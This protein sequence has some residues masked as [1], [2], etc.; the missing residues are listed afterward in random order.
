MVQAPETRRP[1]RGRGSRS[2]RKKTGEYLRN[3]YQAPKGLRRKQKI[4]FAG[5]G[6]FILLLVADALY[7]GAGLNKHMRLAADEL[8][9]GYAA[10]GSGN[11]AE[12][13]VHFDRAAE[14]A[15]TANGLSAHPTVYMASVLPVLEDDVSVVRSLPPAATLAAQAGQRSVEAARSL[16]GTD[17][18]SLARA[19][20]RDGQIQL[21]TVVQTD[22]YLGEIEG[23]LTEAEEELQDASPPHLG[24]VKEAL[25]RSLE[26]ISTARRT[27]TRSHVLLEMLPSFFGAEEPREYLLALQN[28]SEAR[29]TGGVI[30]IYGVLEADDG[31]LKLTHAGPIS[32]LTGKVTPKAFEKVFA[33]APSL[34]AYSAEVRKTYEV[35]YT[36][37]FDQ[38]ARAF[39]DLYRNATGRSLD[40]VIMTDPVALAE[41]TKATGPIQGTG[42]D[43]PVGPDNAVQLMLHDAYE[44]FRTDTQARNAF[45]VSLIKNFYKALSDPLDAPVFV[46]SFGAASDSRHVRILSVDPADQ[47][48]LEE[49]GVTGGLPEDGN[50]QLIYHNN[51]G[52][53]GTDFFLER[54][55]E[56]KVAI[57]RDGNLEVSGELTLT[58]G[59]SG[60]LTPVEYSY[61]RLVD[62]GVNWMELNLLMPSGSENA[63]FRIDGS[64]PETELKKVGSFPVA[65]TNLQIAPGSSEVVAFRYTVPGA[66][67]LLKGGSLEFYLL[68]PAGVR[69]DEYSITFDPPPGYKVASA[70][71][72]KRVGS[73]SLLFSGA[74]YRAL[75]LNVSVEGL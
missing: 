45:L 18:Q 23:L 26:E 66:A 4:A 58:N 12:A 51:L 61:E 30:A 33:S 70:D 22:E 2:T 37:D 28:L 21:D 36:P 57:T 65:S 3:I 42:V 74:L 6:I 32:E 35:N 27:T 20:F 46:Q 38:V 43:T 11:L 52:R 55:Q 13:D 24:I 34:D 49:L 63:A 9:E 75:D 17:P 25:A 31:Y 14:A 7:V 59:A 5:I 67:D 56:T 40:G 39:L 64:E 19:F 53:N 8:N 1:S 50:T 62:P 16:G 48:A 72:G 73:G 69:P 54:S 71:G 60:R 15:R 68:P 29:A 44:V 10:L 41:F 47:A